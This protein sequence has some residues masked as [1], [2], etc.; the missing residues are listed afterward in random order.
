MVP[1]RNQCVLVSYYPAFRRKVI[2]LIGLPRVFVASMAMVLVP[3]ALL[4]ILGL[5]QMAG[6]PLLP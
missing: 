3:L 1:L 2:A 6:W 5:A 4:W